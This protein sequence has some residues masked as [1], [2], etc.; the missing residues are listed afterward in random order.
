MYSQFP[1]KWDT[2][3][4]FG[5]ADS[6]EPR[7]ARLFERALRNG[8]CTGIRQLFSCSTIPLLDLQEIIGRCRVTHRYE[9]GTRTIP[10][11]QI[12]G[13]LNKAGDFD[14]AFR[15]LHRHSETRWLKVA[16]AMLRGSSLP[17]I[18]L[19]Q[20]GDTYFVK[21]G[22]HRISVARALGYRFLDAVITVWAIELK[23]PKTL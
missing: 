12:K 17:P 1:V 9:A 2:S 20:V 4:H 15:P 22:H 16:T 7:A 23:R 3:R 8:K 13:S 18:E 14:Q 11:E 21:D 6:I 10:L 5:K 19:I